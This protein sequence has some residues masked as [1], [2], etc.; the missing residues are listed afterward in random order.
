MIFI[1][2]QRR[3]S[4]SES[5][6]ERCGVRIGFLSR[7]KRQRRDGS[8]VELCKDC[9]RLEDRETGA[10]AA[11]AAHMERP[12][13]A[14]ASGGPASPCERGVQVL[15]AAFRAETGIDVSGD[16]MAMIRLQEAVA[17]ALDAV[18]AKGEAEINLP[19]LTA[20][21]SGPKHLVAKLR[22]QDIGE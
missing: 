22:R 5:F 1:N 20:N 2:D 13:A 6:C 7:K 4:M 16:A 15:L 8:V 12:S 10:A 11:P 19:F 17:K 9:A 14:A 18:R 21:A 3:G